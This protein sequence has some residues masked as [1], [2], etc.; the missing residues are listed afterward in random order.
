MVI[1][2]SSP[3]QSTPT[4]GPQKINL[5]EENPW[6]F[7]DE[8]VLPGEQIGAEKWGKMLE[9]TQETGREYDIVV[10]TNGKKILVNKINEGHGER[11][12][13]DSDKGEKSPPDFS[14][15]IFPQ[16]VLKGLFGRVRDIVSVH[17]HPETEDS[18]HLPTTTFSADDV[19]IYLDRGYRTVIMLDK[20]GAHMLIGINPYINRKQINPAE[21]INEAFE[22]AEKNTETIAE[23]M[24]EIAKSLVPFGIKYYFTSSIKQSEEGFVEFRDVLSPSSDVEQSR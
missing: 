19:Y 12:D 13:Y 22:K 5:L 4:L 1:M 6:R 8:I 7:Q 9:K 18:K 14:P 17:T 20:G 24:V 23:V 10:S 15:P 11:P 21:I 16:G 2:I 3:E